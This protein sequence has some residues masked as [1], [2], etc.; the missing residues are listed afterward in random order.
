MPEILSTESAS[1]SKL[2][3]RSFKI[4]PSVDSKLVKVFIYEMS[5]SNKQM[6]F[7]EFII[8]GLSGFYLSA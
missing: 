2:I 3:N 4:H 1:A 5:K 6:T 7:T 8:N